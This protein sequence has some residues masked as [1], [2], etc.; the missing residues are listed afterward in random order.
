MRQA[1]AALFV[2]ALGFQAVACSAPVEAEVAD[3]ELVKSVTRIKGT[4]A[5]PDFLSAYGDSVYFATNYGYADQY[6]SDF[7]HDIW[8]KPAKGAAKILYKNLQNH[9][10]AQVVTPLG[11]YE[12]NQGYGGIYRY[13]LDGKGKETLIFDGRDD[14]E[15]GFDNGL[16]GLDADATGL[17]AVLH[18]PSLDD[19]EETPPSKVFALSP[20]GKKQVT[21]GSVVG[22][23]ALRIAGN[24]VYVGT[25]NGQVYA[26][27]RS[28]S[29]SLKQI[30]WAE[31]AV[32]D[33]LV[34]GDD[35]FFAA[36][37]IYQANIKGGQTTQLLTDKHVSSLAR[38]REEIVFGAFDEGVFTLNLKTL[39]TKPLYTKAKTPFD[40]IFANDQ[41]IFADQSRG[42]PQYLDDG[43]L[44]PFD[45]GVYTFNY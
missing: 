6:G 24:R 32:N 21:L 16:A 18:Y 1:L 3:D 25:V 7:H 10:F 41:V 11:I 27:L 14:T 17:V 28:G 39:K 35:V 44:Y 37:G 4:E 38:V 23:T 33:I 20:D 45:G 29:G 30:G 22:F 9:S 15:D 34:D 40:I 2:A 8:V 31:G 36:K 26:G 42:K 5:D 19:N 12:I 43:V 13:P